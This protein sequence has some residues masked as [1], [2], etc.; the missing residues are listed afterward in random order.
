MADREK[1]KA[2]A[3]LVDRMATKLGVD[4]EEKAIAGALRIDDLSEAVLR[5]TGCSNPEHCG[6]W[7]SETPEADDTPG[8]C[9]NRELLTRLR[10]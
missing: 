8:Y 7:L 9:R 10:D 3:A 2:H 1:L 5:C 4:L 6:R